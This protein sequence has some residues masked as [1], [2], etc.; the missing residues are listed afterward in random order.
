M[1]QLSSGFVLHFVQLQLYSFEKNFLHCSLF[2]KLYNEWSI[3]SK[4]AYW[5]SDFS[6]GN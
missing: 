6:V 2:A 3:V 4:K 5:T 1:L